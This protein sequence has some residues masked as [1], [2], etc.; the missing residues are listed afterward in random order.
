[1]AFNG[2][3]RK[4]SRMIGRSIYRKNFFNLF[5]YHSRARIALEGLPS[6]HFA[7]LASD[8]TRKLAVERCRGNIERHFAGRVVGRK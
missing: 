2:K 1:M 5:A 6:N 8:T 4:S 7:F 3:M